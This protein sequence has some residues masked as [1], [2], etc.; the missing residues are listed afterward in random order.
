MTDPDSSSTPWTRR[1]VVAGAL[2]GSL[3]GCSALSD[4]GIV[5]PGQSAESAPPEACQVPSAWYSVQ[6]H[7]RN[8]GAFQ[9][10]RT[11]ITE[12]TI[13]EI[14]GPILGDTS[15]VL[16]AD[17]C[18]ITDQQGVSAFDRTTGER[19][20][21][22]SVDDFVGTSPLVGCGLV[23][24]QTANHLSA[25]DTVTGEE[26][27]QMDFGSGAA[28]PNLTASSA[29][30]FAVG[31]DGAKLLIVDGTTRWHALSESLLHGSGLVDSHLI[32][33]SGADNT[34]G[35]VY[36]LDPTT[37]E[38]QWVHDGIYSI[39]PPALTETYAY[40]TATTGSV[41]KLAL[42]SG[43]QIWAS[44]T[45][46]DGTYSL[47]ALD[48]ARGQVYV[49]TGA[50]GNVVAVSIDTG[51]VVWRADV[52]M[53]A[54]HPVVHTGA[55]LYHPGND[56]RAIDPDTGTVDW[57]LSEY[58]ANGPATLGDDGLWVSA[59]GSLFRVT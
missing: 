10:E 49:S 1:R 16:D 31:S 28:T 47:P 43:D 25:F 38:Q 27:W 45:G 37:G 19:R 33:T 6:N 39:A 17:R 2:V 7:A 12:P 44:D 32:V 59:D 48:H 55:Q 53:Q 15:P 26:R 18:Y 52:G 14:G 5:A 42:D 56:I 23:F 4:S 21:Q 41:H 9:G 57:I 20:W 51:E 30:L 8:S 13:E 34:G 24:S 36:A 40:I 29:G 35:S 58:V 54:S 22:Q 3:S 50:T 46:G 11:T